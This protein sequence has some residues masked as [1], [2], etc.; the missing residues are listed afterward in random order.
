MRVEDY[1]W[2]DTDSEK[3]IRVEVFNAV[4]EGM[5]WLDEQQTTNKVLAVGG[6]QIEGIRAYLWNKKGE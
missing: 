4:S 5:T 2:N 6:E 1:A 3:Q